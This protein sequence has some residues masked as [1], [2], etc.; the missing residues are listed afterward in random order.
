MRW[1]MRMDR[2]W[3]DSVSIIEEEYEEENDNGEYA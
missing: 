2:I 3:K 1:E